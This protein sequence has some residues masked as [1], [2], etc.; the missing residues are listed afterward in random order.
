MKM[1]RSI[2]ALIVA[3]ALL[4]SCKKEY[5]VEGG[6]NN[7]GNPPLGSNCRV[8]Q[9]V[10]LDSASRRGLAS[11]TTFF[12]ATGQG[13]RVVTYD[14]IQD[15]NLFTS[16][17]AYSGDTMRVNAHEYFLLS[18]SKRASSFHTYQ[19]PADTSSGAV[20]FVY[21]YDGSG[22]MSRKD[23]F[24]KGV[25]VPAVRFTYTWGGG[26]LTGVEGAVVVPGLEQKLFTA[27]ME[28]D[29]T[30]KVKNFINFFP[31]GYDN[32]PY[33]MTLDLGMKSRNALVKLTASNY[34]NLGNISQTVTTTFTGHVFSPDGYLVEW[35]AK[36]DEPAS[37]GLPVGLTRFNYLCK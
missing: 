9:V 25:P 4:P 23:I 22:Y 18:S 1:M 7:G 34:D 21:S 13:T 19:N 37:S 15:A 35:M 31:D 24:V 14:S 29:A 20:T 33:T 17:I 16:D 26:N 30:K 2:L 11:F 3:C 36:G 6:V 28:Y 12:N 5:S 8:N 32:F 10:Q 27:K